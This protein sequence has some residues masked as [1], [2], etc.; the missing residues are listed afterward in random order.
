MMSTDTESEM[1][2]KPSSSSSDAV[3]TVM[4]VDDHPVVREGL[5]AIFKSQKD[6][7]VVGEASNG[8]EACE[9]SD[10]LLPDVLLL[11]LRMPKKDG[12]QVINELSGRRGPK[13]RIIVMTT[14][15][16]EEDIRRT[17]KA[18]ARGFLAKGTAPQQIRD[19]VRRVAQGESLLPPSIAS[20]LAE[21][22]AHPELSE[23]EL[24]VLQYM[25]SGRSNKEIGQVLYIS[26]NTV[27]AHVKSILAK[28]D[29]M[30]RTE[31][32]AIATKRGLIVSPG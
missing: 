22:M 31:A 1:A 30:G 16:S 27:K 8:E 29:A 26:E 15:E 17:L 14:Y 13:P 7:K 32:I 4:I 6:I 2:V 12:L 19:A 28:L 24:Q 18:G 25:A 3:I 5:A 23:R 20:K 11:D 21:S 10:Q 9:M